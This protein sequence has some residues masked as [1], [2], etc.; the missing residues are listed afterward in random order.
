M[1]KVRQNLKFQSQNSEKYNI[2]FKLSDLKYSLDK[3]HNT[4]AG[5][6]DIPPLATRGIEIGGCFALVAGG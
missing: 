3:S 6:D 2:P 1:E 5:P 4:A